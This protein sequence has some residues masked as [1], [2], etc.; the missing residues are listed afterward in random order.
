MVAVED[1]LDP[2]DNEGYGN[3]VL[4]SARD[5]EIGTEV[6]RLLGDLLVEL[7]DGADMVLRTYAARMASLAR[8]ELDLD[9]VRAGLAA[10]VLAARGGE[11]R[12]VL[13][14]V[15]LLWRSASVLGADPVA[16]F[17][18]A[19][20]RDGGSDLL[21]QFAGRDPADQT[22]ESMGYV[23]VDDPDLGFFYERTW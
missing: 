3:W 7:P 18:E 1:V 12:D 8:R 5:D 17:G 20:G 23:E 14:V 16:L 21:E 10:V 4:P 22:I 15:P 9:R 6:E 2:A 19:A 11:P 13:V